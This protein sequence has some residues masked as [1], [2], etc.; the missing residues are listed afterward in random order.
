MGTLDV[1]MENAHWI[2]LIFSRF[3]IKVP[4]SM[5]CNLKE[6]RY[7]M[8]QNQPK[9]P[10]VLS[11]LVSL[12]LTVPLISSQVVAAESSETETQSLL[13]APSVLPE[14]AQPLTDQLP[15]GAAQAPSAVA[16]SP[17]IHNEP[18]P[19]QP[20]PI[21]LNRAV[22]DYVK[23]FLDQPGGLKVALERNRPF[24]P[25]M[26]KVMKERGVPDDLVYL[27]CAE[28]SFSSR[29]KGYW[30][31]NQD[32]AQRFGLRVDKWIDERRDPIKSTRAAA[33]FL[34][35]LHDQADND[36]RV[37]LVGWNMGE[38]YLGQYWLLA[39]DRNFNK[40]SDR[41]PAR[42]F[43][44]LHRF[45]AVAYIAHNAAAYGIGPVSY[46]DSPSYKTR[47]VAGGTLLA[48]VASRFKTTV[49][50]LRMLNP[51]LQTNQIPP[52]NESYPIR[53]PL[54]RTIPGV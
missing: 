18:R 26:V 8:N 50:K 32:T 53:I 16:S 45:M 39:G 48:T 51:A 24:M 29:G 6:R 15:A 17:F 4:F 1:L 13:V 38:G 21:I 40:F 41:L 31:F 2:R 54:G 11:F 36:W 14:G 3:R 52:T 47:E 22:Q 46:P 43:S 20:F 44:L 12:L 25:E 37:A 19:A 9:T 34:A 10:I 28:S 49:A 30:Q 7:T 35:Q 33:E 23:D 5:E 27:A 42:T